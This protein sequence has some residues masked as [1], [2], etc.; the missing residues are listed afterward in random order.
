MGSQFVGTVYLLFLS[1]V[2]TG[3]R[4]H[5]VQM[6]NWCFRPYAGIAIQLKN[7]SIHS[8]FTHP[9]FALSTNCPLFSWLLFNE[10]NYNA[11][12][13][14]GLLEDVP[15]HSRDPRAHSFY[16]MSNIL[17]KHVIV[18]PMIQEA[19]ENRL[20]RFRN[21]TLVGFHIR[22]GDRHS[23]FK[24]TRD[25]IYGDDV[26]QFA[27]CSVVQSHPGAVLFVASDSTEAKNVVKSSTRHP[28]ITVASK[29]RHSNGHMGQNTNIDILAESFTDMLT[30]GA[31]DYVVGTWKSTF[32]VIAAAF[33]GNIPYFVAR[34]KACF[35]PNYVDYWS[36]CL[37]LSREYAMTP[38]HV[39]KA[40]SRD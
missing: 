29:A 19:V 26:Y 2:A 16:L 28:V 30:V 38:I 13:K 10:E 31:C 12:V 15:Y 8:I 5:R 6:V 4:L 9:S 23:D 20:R 1:H 27:R 7:E 11:L 22:K 18:S 35:Q 34:R 32:S 3:K 40:F 37:L 17:R 39:S 33:Q 21:S 36:V 24:E 25:F 14:I